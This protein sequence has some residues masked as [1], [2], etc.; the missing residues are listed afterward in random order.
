MKS[1]LV[2]SAIGLVFCLGVVALPSPAAHAQQAMGSLYYY[3]IPRSEI[4]KHYQG[5]ATFMESESREPCQNYQAPPAGYEMKGCH[6]SRS[7]EAIAWLT[8][9]AGAPGHAYTILFDLNKSSIRSGAENKLD[10]IAREI[11]REIQA[12][13]QTEVTVS[14]F[15]DRSGSKKY[16]QAL[17]ER[18]TQAVVEALAARGVTVEAG[19][20][21]SYGETGA[22]AVATADGISRQENR[23]VVVYFAR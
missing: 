6:L 19:N 22:A 12:D 20:Q 16:N 8:P 17:S 11:Q 1:K 10:Q 5:W 15:A 9:A 14:G 13:P 18:R 4:Q 2:F 23:R 21:R 7:T 3:P